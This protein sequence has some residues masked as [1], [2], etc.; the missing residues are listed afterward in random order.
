MSESQPEFF[1][2]RCLGRGAPVLLSELGWLIHVIGDHFPDDAQHA[3]DDEWIEF[4]LRRGWS[5]LTQDERISTQ[6]AVRTLL[7]Q[8]GGCVHCLDNANLTAA[9]KAA[10]FDAHRRSIFQRVRD[11]R[12]GFYVLHEFGP[13]RRKRIG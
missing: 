2:D 6:P 4:G 8:Y 13:P 12:V 5:L 11:R 7:N 1:A 9:A 10:R 3:G